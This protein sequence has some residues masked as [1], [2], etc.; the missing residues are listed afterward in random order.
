MIA[1][2]VASEVLVWIKLNEGK[3]K[4][5][6]IATYIYKVLIYWRGGIC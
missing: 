5:Y 3:N 2:A 4:V 1:I 6:N